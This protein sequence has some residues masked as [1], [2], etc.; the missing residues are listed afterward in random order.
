MSTRAIKLLQQQKIPFEICKYRH[1]Q[2]GAAFAA[3]AVAWDLERMVKTLVCELDAGGYRLALVPGNRQLDLKLLARGCGVKRASM[4]DVP[5]A[6]RL[7]GYLVG[8]ISPFATRQ[9][10][11]VLME[12]ALLVHALV[13]INAGQR[14][15]L[16][17]LRPADIQSV[18]AARAVPLSV[19]SGAGE[20]AFLPG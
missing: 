12:Q 11:P 6:E 16:L 1:V 2:K 14:G 19:A 10:L 5:T 13:M 3:Q 15:T 18:L 9:S 20:R 8:G 4:V 7:T 17:K